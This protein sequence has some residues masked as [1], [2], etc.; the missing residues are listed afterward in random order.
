[1]K[2]RKKFYL[3]AYKISFKYLQKFRVLRNSAPFC[4]HF[5]KPIFTNDYNRQFQTKVIPFFRSY[6]TFRGNS[7][8]MI[9]AA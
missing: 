1:M 4:N 5:F 7:F 6:K 3:I 8:L 2:K 9:D